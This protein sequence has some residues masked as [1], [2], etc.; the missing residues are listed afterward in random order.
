MAKICGYRVENFRIIAGL[1]DHPVMTLAKKSA[2][3][4]A[5]SESQLVIVVHGQAHAHAARFAILDCAAPILRF[6]QFPVISRLH[7]VRLAYALIVRRFS[8]IALVR[9]FAS[10]AIVLALLQALTRKRP[11]APRALA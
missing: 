4:F 6:I 1:A 11:A 10:V 3:R 5:V 7:A 8:L 2:D 9:Y